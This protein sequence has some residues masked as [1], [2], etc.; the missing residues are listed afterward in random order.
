MLVAHMAAQQ[1]RPRCA[2]RLIGFADERHGRIGAQRQINELHSFE[3]AVA[4]ATAA[5][6]D[7]EVSRLRAEGGLMGPDEVTALVF[8]DEES[9]PARAG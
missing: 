4:A 5:L 1:Q 8:S 6:G 7:A 3:Q 2:A 9:A